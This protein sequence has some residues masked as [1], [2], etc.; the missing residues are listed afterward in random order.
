MWFGLRCGWHRNLWE[1]SPAGLRGL[2]PLRAQ[3]QAASAGSSSVPLPGNGLVR[4]GPASASRVPAHPSRRGTPGA[5]NTNVLKEG[6]LFHKF[7]VFH[8]MVLVTFGLGFDSVVLGNPTMTYLWLRTPLSG[9]VR[10]GRPP[11][12]IS[13]VDKIPQGME[14]SSLPERLVIE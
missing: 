7:P 5:H 4:P 14:G 3:D 6:Q 10:M 13:H 1:R 9:N 11:R 2:P 8:F 12:V